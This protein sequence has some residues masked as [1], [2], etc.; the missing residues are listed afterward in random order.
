[1]SSVNR[2]HRVNSSGK[3]WLSGLLASC[4]GRSTY[5]RIIIS[6]YYYHFEGT[7]LDSQLLTFEKEDYQCVF[8][9]LSFLVYVDLFDFIACFF[10]IFDVFTQLCL[11]VIFATPRFFVL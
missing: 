3:A 10:H 2:S 6:I 1:M 7:N 5:T 4:P 9:S 8:C 11:C